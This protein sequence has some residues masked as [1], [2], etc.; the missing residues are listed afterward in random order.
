MSEQFADGL[1]RKEDLRAAH[2]QAGVADCSGVFRA[3]VMLVL[4][5]G[6]TGFSEVIAP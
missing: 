1:V 5:G 2:E 4:F 6:M 3:P